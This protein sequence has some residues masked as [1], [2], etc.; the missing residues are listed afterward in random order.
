MMK[1]TI[2][3]ALAFCLVSCGNDDV[4]REI[5]REPAIVNETPPQV[6]NEAQDLLNLIQDENDYRAGLGQTM[7]SSGLSCTLQTFT[8]GDRIQASVAGHNTLS[9]LKTVASYSLLSGFNQEQSS[10]NDGMSVMPPS[11][12]NMYKTNYLLKCSGYFIV[13]NS[14]H[15]KFDLTS[16]DASVLYVNGSKLIDND[17]SHGTTKLSETKYL[18]R[19]VH[20]IRLDYA[21]NGGEQS[22]VLNMNDQLLKGANLLH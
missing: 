21:Q 17:N 18:R 13:L 8:G 11:L 1:S 9:G 2:L 15:Y 19:G 22:L 16:D 14:D 20:S 5:V 3:V 12:R 4:T 7:L 6:S 10:V